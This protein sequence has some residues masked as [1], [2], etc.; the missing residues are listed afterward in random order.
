MK[1]PKSLWKKIEH[2]IVLVIFF[3][4][5]A[6]NIVILIWGD[7]LGLVNEGHDVGDTQLD[8]APDPRYPC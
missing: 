8:C 7:D 1:P 5:I 6:F 4:S 2:W 3:G